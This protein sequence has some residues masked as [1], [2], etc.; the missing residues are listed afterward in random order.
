MSTRYLVDPE[1]LPMIDAFPM[2]SLSLDTLEQARAAINASGDAMPQPP[3]APV[4]HFA[5]SRDGGPE[6]AVLVFKPEGDKRRAAILHIHGGG[7]VL[8]TAFGLRQGPSTVAANHD[9]VVVSVDYRLSPEAA[10]PG[11]QEDCYAALDWLVAQ[12]DA[13][14]VDVARIAVM[15][16][17]AG[18]GLAAALAQMVR[19]RGEHRLCGQILVYPMIDHRTGGPDDCYCNPTVGEFIWTRQSNQF[20]WSCLQGDYALDDDRI[21]WFSPSLAQNLSGL[22]PAYITLGT[23]DLFFDEDLDYARRLCAAGVPAELHSYAG[24]FHGFNAMAETAVAKEFGRNLNAAIARM[25]AES[26]R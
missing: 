20:G 8:G 1:L 24:A 18:G 22:A 14:S 23:L 25:L 12:A 3:I 7:M 4:Q 26:G 6:V 21:G 19:D 2:R 15:G 17:S 5:K 16:E 13:L 11:P 10:F 9:V